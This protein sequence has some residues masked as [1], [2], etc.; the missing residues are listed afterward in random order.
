MPYRR[1]MIVQALEDNGQKLEDID[2]FV[3]RG[4][5]LLSLEGGTYEIN[6]VLLDHA[7]RGANGVQHPAQLGSQLAHAFAEEADVFNF[8][9]E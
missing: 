8:I 7:Y 4:G 1:D 2:A 9:I 3:G 6:D 5:G